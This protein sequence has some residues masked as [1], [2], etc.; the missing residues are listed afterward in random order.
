MVL[1]QHSVA[2]G[3]GFIIA[4]IIFII[5]IGMIFVTFLPLFE[6]GSSGT[7]FGFPSSSDISSAS[8]VNVTFKEQGQPTPTN[9][10]NIAYNF[11]IVSGEHVYY[12]STSHGYFELFEFKASSNVNSSSFYSHYY[13]FYHCIWRGNL[14]KD[15]MSTNLSLLGFTYFYFQ[16]ETSIPVEISIGFNGDYNF[17][18]AHFGNA[19]ININNVAEAVI[20]NM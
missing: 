17:L 16:W 20:M 2:K 4:F 14:S 15:S 6:R 13:A 11:G 1:R 7:T 8:G 3:F 18:L 10:S 12:N 9:G 19:T 5:I